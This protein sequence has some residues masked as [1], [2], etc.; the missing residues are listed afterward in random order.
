MRIGVVSDTHGKV[1]PTGEAVTVLRAEGVDLVIHCGDIGSKEVVALFSDWPTHFVL[2]NVDQDERELHRAIEE[3][4][5]KFHGRFG[6]L[7]LEHV[8]IAFLHSDDARRF[9]ETCQSGAWDLVCY[10]HTH[11]AE[12][13]YEGRTLVLNPGAIY[14]AS[15][16]TIAIVELPTLEVQHLTIGA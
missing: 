5:M 10:G 2:G 14:R 1:N 12:G 11:R 16:R 13:H 4:G 6:S 7:E 8:K 9:Q 15:P 3:L